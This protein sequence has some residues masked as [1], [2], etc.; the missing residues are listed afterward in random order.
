M[1]MTPAQ[2]IGGNLERIRRERNLTQVELAAR[3]KKWYGLGWNQSHISRA[4]R[5]AYNAILRID[6]LLLLCYALDIPAEDF[7]A[8]ESD[9]TLGQY[10]LGSAKELRSFVN[11]TREWVD[12]V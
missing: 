2:L 4:E 11:N 9:I 3:L 5:G 6:V 8:G 10:G 7:F 12:N 1:G